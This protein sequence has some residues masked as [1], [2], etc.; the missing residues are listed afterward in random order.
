MSDD[1]PLSCSHRRRLLALEKDILSAQSLPS[2]PQPIL[3]DALFHEQNIATQPLVRCTRSQN[4]PPPSRISD[5]QS[6]PETIAAASLLSTTRKLVA[7]KVTGYRFISMLAL[8]GFGLGKYFTNADGQSVLS[9]GL[10]F[11]YGVGVGVMYVECF[12]KVACVHSPE[13]YCCFRI[14]ERT[15]AKGMASGCLRKTGAILWFS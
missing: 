12:L 1:Q 9:N 5:E 6:P 7:I 10:D 14:G 15:A 8:I 4:L 2:L 3:V 11:G 13:D